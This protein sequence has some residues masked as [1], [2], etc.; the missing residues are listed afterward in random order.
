MGEI[1]N[2]RQA[3]KRLERGRREADA[4]SN[5][6]KF[7]RTAA[8]KRAEAQQTERLQRAQ[9]GARLESEK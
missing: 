6:V 3:R 7:G 8:E 9:D 2:L 4:A 5:R 1:V